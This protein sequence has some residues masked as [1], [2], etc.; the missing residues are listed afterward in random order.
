MYGLYPGAF[1]GWKP[2]EQMRGAITLHIISMKYVNQ[3]DCIICM[4]CM[5]LIE[6]YE[7]YAHVR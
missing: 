3:M 2:S 5:I 6:V 4:I 1:G 7:V